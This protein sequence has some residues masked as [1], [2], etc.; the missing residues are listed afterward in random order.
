MIIFGL[1]KKNLYKVDAVISC[2]VGCNCSYKLIYYSVWV[3]ALV[4]LCCVRVLVWKIFTTEIVIMPFVVIHV[5][6]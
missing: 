4:F 1:K 5:F 2:E 3:Y 6:S